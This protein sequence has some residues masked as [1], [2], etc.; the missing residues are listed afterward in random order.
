MYFAVDDYHD[1]A[2][3]DGIH[4]TEEGILFTWVQYEVG[5]DLTECWDEGEFNIDE[6]GKTVFTS[7]EDAEK[8]LGKLQASYEQ[9]KGG[10]QK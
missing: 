6:L 2:V 5:Y 10:E 1:S 8:A 3:I 9:V 7:R 4:I